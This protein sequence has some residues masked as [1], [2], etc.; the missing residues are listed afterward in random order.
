MKEFKQILKRLRS[1]KLGQYPEMLNKY[2][3]SWDSFGYYRRFIRGY[4]NIARTLN[5]LVGHP[6]KKDKARKKAKGSTIPLA[7]EVGT[8]KVL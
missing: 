3:V 5:D 6:L 2:A 4:A 1:L 7:G 8:T